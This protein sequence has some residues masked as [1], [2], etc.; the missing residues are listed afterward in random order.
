MQLDPTRRK[1]EP[2]TSGGL[3]GYFNEQFS[4]IKQNIPGYSADNPAIL[5]WSAPGAP[6]VQAPS[7][8]FTKDMAENYPWL[9]AVLQYVPVIGAFTRGKQITDPVQQQ[10]YTLHGK[11]TSFMGP[12]ASDFGRPDLHLTFG[13]LNQYRK[14]FATVTDVNGLTWHQ[15]ATQLIKTDFYR[16]LPDRTPSSKFKNK[17]AAALQILITEYKGYAKEIFEQTTAKGKQI[18]EAREELEREELETEVMMQNKSTT[19]E[20]NQKVN[21]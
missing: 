14:I 20:F 11:G 9:S 19:S 17:K 5:D 7:L 21:Y 6:P 4:T 2:D 1:V 10:L 8:F 15:R 3:G 16:N 12:T 13:E 18:K